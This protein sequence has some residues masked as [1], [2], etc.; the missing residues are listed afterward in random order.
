MTNTFKLIGLTKPNRMTCEPLNN[1]NIF[2]VQS[3]L[4]KDIFESLFKYCEGN[5]KDK[6]QVVLKHEGLNKEGIP[7]NPEFLRILD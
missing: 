7:S 1:E 5:W 4:T 3:G 2:W 6:K